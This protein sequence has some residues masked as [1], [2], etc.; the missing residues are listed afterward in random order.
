MKEVVPKSGHAKLSRN[1]EIVKNCLDGVVEKTQISSVSM[2]EKSFSAILLE[3]GPTPVFIIDRGKYVTITV[4]AMFDKSVKE[5]M[6]KLPPEL[7]ETYRLSFLQE[8]LSNHR[9]GVA[10]IP[11]QFKVITE[12]QGFNLIQNIHLS[13]SPE[14]CTRVTDGIQEV[15]SVAIR[16]M[17]MIT[18][19]LAPFSAPDQ[20]PKPPPETMYQ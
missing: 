11:P 3:W 18:N 10:Y 13:G 19:G 7:L 6:K 17:T 2:G 1:L 9:T 12:I 20:Q 16:T 5:A 15:I 4:Q 8:I 14:S